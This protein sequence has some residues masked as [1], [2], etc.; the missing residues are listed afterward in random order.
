MA[1]HD[2]SVRRGYDFDSSKINKKKRKSHMVETKGQLLYEWRHLKK[3]LKMRGSFIASEA[4]KT[5][6]PMPH[7]LFKIIDGDICDWERM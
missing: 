5:K 1:V 3:K 4:A 6:K 7:P 2:E